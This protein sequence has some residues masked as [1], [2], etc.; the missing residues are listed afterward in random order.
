MKKEL[1][2]ENMTVDNKKETA[3]ENVS[4]LAKAILERK[5]MAEFSVHKALQGFESKGLVPKRAVME[6]SK[7]LEKYE[8][9]GVGQEALKLQA[10]DALRDSVT[11]YRD[12]KF[13]ISNFNFFKEELFNFID[14]VLVESELESIEDLDKAAMIFFDIDGLKAVND[15]SLNLHKAGDIYLKKISEALNKGRT[16]QWLES[17]GMEISP[18]RRSGDEFMYAIRADKPL[19]RKIDFVGIDGENVENTTFADYI[20]AKIKEDIGS[21]DMKD[22]QDFSDHGQREK[23]KGLSEKWPD[24]FQFK[25]SISGGS[26]S[27]LD[28]MRRIFENGENIEGKLYEELIAGNLIGPMIDVSDKAMAVDKEKGKEARKN[29][30]I[31]SERLLEEVYRSV[32]QEKEM[33][34]SCPVCGNKIRR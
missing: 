24:G 15:K 19:T 12:E 21:L 26:A 3:P 17:L 1:G 18:A 31:E 23:Y 8:K 9:A 29:S 14:N 16:T 27:L 28:A 11:M 33:E 22:V 30:E 7:R 10:E 4:D 6:I 34:F 13:E 5:R 20:I 2:M 25:A 32:R